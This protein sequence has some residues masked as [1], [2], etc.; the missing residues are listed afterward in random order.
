MMS[1]DAINAI[2]TKKYRCQPDPDARKLKAAPELYARTRDST[3]GNTSMDC[4]GLNARCITIFVI[5]SSTTITAL[6][7]NQMRSLS[8]DAVLPRAVQIFRAAAADVRVGGIGP[9]IGAV[10]PAALAFRVLTGHDHDAVL[11]LYDFRLGCD[12][13]EAQIVA[14]GLQQ[15]EP[16]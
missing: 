5:W 13:H 9:D 14:Q 6:K 11:T 2:A 7:P 1:A 15:F 16:V 10:V 12:Q 8:M 4:P 3:G